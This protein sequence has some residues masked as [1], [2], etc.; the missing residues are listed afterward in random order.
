M[1]QTGRTIIP[2]KMMIGFDLGGAFKLEQDQKEKK[3]IVN[4]H[5]GIKG[6]SWKDSSNFLKMEPH[7]GN[8]TLET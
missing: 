5:R 3:E 7:I 8:R 1:T 4:Y 6:P 2:K